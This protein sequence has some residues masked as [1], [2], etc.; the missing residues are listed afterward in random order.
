MKTKTS[1]NI[2]V[3]NETRRVAWRAPKLGKKPD[4]ERPAGDEI[5][6]VSETSFPQAELES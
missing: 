4:D 1:T 2:L 6:E 5:E 3:A